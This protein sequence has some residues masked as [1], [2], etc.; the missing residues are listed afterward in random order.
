MKFFKNERLLITILI[1]FSACLFLVGLGAM[2][3]TDPDET[4]YAET[5][6]EM[7]NRGEFLTPYIFGEPQF[8]KPPLYYWLVMLSFKAFGVNEFTARIP[9]AIFGIL[10]VV[11]VYLLGK[12][13]INKRAGFFSGIITATG[14]KYLALSRA[15]V[16]DMA[17]GVFILY[18]FLFFFYGYLSRE[19]K[20]KWYLFSSVSLSLAVLTK[21]PVGVFLPVVIIGIYLILA[22]EL[23][24]LKEIPLLRGALLFLAVSLPWYLL[25]YRVHGKGFIDVF[26]GF[27]NIARFLEPEHKWGDVFYYYGPVVVAG[28]LPWAAFLPLGI[29][30]GF[31]ERNKEV[32]KANLFLAIWF[33][34]IFLFFSFSR[35]KLPT[36]IFPLYPAV[37]LS[38]GRLLDVFLHK[39]F[40][41]NMERGMNISLC[42]FLALLIGGMVGLYIVARRKYPSVVNM[43]LVTGIAFILLMAVFAILFLKRKYSA[44]LIAYMA[45]FIIFVFP[46]SYIILPEIGKYVSSKPISEKLLK[47]IKPGEKLGAETRYR[48]G[49]AFYTNRED[50][51]DVHPHHI[52]TNFLE[53]KERVWCIIK[54]KNHIQLYTDDRNPYGKPTYVVYRLGKKIIVTNKKPR[55]GKFLKIRTKDDPY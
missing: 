48:R 37:A 22:K 31:R 27:H 10:G 12:I 43:S 20:V 7:M 50:V 40:T 34:V 35:T 46:M 55:D 8:E 3:L 36:Y 15:C 29:W 33:L 2:P 51:L 17:L 14:V 32:K 44:S 54:E 24:K 1:L 49:V 5:A 47:F 30:Q 16:T 26:F 52:I 28:F 9:S 19:G 4:F 21:G 6:K 53:K 45:S 38:V 23:K 39:G 41:R 42:L 18:T 11:G 13:L 25:M